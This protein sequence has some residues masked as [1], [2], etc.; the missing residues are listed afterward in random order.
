LMAVLR[1]ASGATPTVTPT[2][3]SAATRTATPA[4]TRTPAA[5][6]TPPPTLPPTATLPAGAL[7]VSGGSNGQT[8]TAP[9]GAVLGLAYEDP[10]WSWSDSFDPTILQELAPGQLRVTA[11][12]QSQVSSRGVPRCYAGAACPRGIQQVTFTLLAGSPTST[13]TATATSTPTPL[14]RATAAA[15]PSGR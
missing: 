9:V 14:T 10:A 8:M 11:T 2:V 15:R 3:T 12:G 7:F 5:T 6:R 13:A 1:A 4:P